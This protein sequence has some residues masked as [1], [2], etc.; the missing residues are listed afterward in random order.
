M[1]SVYSNK[2][3]VVFEGDWRAPKLLPF[4]SRC[5][6]QHPLAWPACDKTSKNSLSEVAEDLY[7]NYYKLRFNINSFSHCTFW[8]SIL[9]KFGH[10]CGVSSTLIKCVRIMF[11]VLGYGWYGRGHVWRLP[12]KRK[13]QY[14]WIPNSDLFW[15]RMF[16]YQI[17]TI[18][19]KKL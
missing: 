5:S 6:S 9:T 16:C 13:V 7:L 10:F 4:L 17:N 11:F 8:T 19:G 12:C 14:H 1:I 18:Y 15:V 2:F 3:W